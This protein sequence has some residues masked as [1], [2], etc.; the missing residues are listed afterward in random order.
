[1]GLLSED[2]SCEVAFCR[3]FILRIQAGYL[4]RQYKVLPGWYCEFMNSGVPPLTLL[5]AA[6]YFKEIV[7]RHNT[8][9]ICERFNR[10]ISEIQIDLRLVHAYRDNTKHEYQ[11]IA[12]VPTSKTEISVLYSFIIEHNNGNTESK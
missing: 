7:A 4:H 6:M 10:P 2:Y 5:Q 11:I 3:Q 8:D 9:L 12:D 1:M